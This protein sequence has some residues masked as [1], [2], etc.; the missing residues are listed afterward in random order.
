MFRAYVQAPIFYHSLDPLLS[1]ISRA[2]EKLTTYNA[3]DA[4]ATYEDTLYVRLEKD[5]KCKDILINSMWDVGWSYCVCIEEVQQ[6][7][8]IV[9]EF[10]L[11]WLIEE[12]AKEILLFSC[13]S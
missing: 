4:D 12:I 8:H 11:F 6:V 5:L 13:C 2:F 7:V 10:I 1:E 3:I 9:G